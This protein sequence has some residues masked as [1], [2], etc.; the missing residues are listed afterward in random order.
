[1]TLKIIQTDT[2]HFR[3]DA[4]GQI[5]YWEAGLVNAGL[6]EFATYVW[7]AD[8]LVDASELVSFISRNNVATDLD[9]LQLDG[10][11]TNRYTSKCCKWRSR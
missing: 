1:M 5:V 2:V 8:Y 7:N 10:E 6:I 11:L 4:D 9:Q 3:R